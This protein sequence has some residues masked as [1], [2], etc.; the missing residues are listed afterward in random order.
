MYHGLIGIPGITNGLERIE[1][2]I[3]RD[4]SIP[5]NSSGHLQLG[6]EDDNYSDNGYSG[7]DNGTENQCAGEG[8]A[9]VDVI[10]KHSQSGIAY[11]RPVK[12]TQAD[13]TPSG[14]S[15]NPGG[16]QKPTNI[17]KSNFFLGYVD[18]APDSNHCIYWRD[19]RI[20]KAFQ[21]RLTK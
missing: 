9:Y 13:P 3:G 8:N 15:G 20:G 1:N 16:F 5:E 14:P 11:Q 4:I 18:R 17:S 12:Q 19:N 6:Y 7:H 10:I 21:K 2:Y